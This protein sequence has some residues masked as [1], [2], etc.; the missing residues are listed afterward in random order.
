MIHYERYNQHVHIEIRKF[1]V[2]GY[3]VYNTINL[4]IHT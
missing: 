4:H 1:I 2:E 3:A